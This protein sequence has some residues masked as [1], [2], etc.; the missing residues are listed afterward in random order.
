MTD[1]YVGIGGNLDQ[2]FSTIQQAIQKLATTDGISHLITSPIYQ[3]SPVSEIP[4]PPFL[5]CVCRFSCELPLEQLWEKMQ[6]IEIELGKIPKPKNAPRI[7]DLDLLFFGPKVYHSSTL[8]LPHPKWHERLFVLAPLADV[9][10]TTPLGIN[11]KEMLQKFL[12]PHN[13]QVI[14]CG[15]LT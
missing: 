6:K 3:T 7:I 5:N 10:D 8:T 12:N 13:E 4:Q 14:V 11:M 2:T 15:A 9:T 1:C